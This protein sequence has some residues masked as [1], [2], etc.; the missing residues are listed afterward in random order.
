MSAVSRSARLS[1][2][3]SSQSP[4]SQR[5]AAAREAAT[6]AAASSTNAACTGAPLKFTSIASLS[7]PLSFPSL[8]TEAQNGLQAA[9]QAVNGECALGR[10]IEV[11]QCDDK[12]DP[13]E[14]TKCG[15]QAN[16]DGSIALFG[17]SGVI[18]RRHER[19]E[20][21]R[22]PHGGRER[23][24]PD[25]PEVVLDQLP[26]HPGRGRG[27]HRRR[28]RRAR[29]PDGLHRQPHNPHLRRRPPRRLRKVSMSSWTRCSSR[30]IR[31]TS[32]PS[33]R[34]SPTGSRVGSG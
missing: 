28:G 30:P 14:A 27:R 33:R 20:L 22:R 1:S 10:P 21:A 5:A 19:R 23:L 6:V 3:F 15:R 4:A 2:R 11:V 25:R 9:L 24:R 16:D 26:A 18:P 13:N 12:G 32:L 17:S 31:R 29:R 7:G 8:T 34:R